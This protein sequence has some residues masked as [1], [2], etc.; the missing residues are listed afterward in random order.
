MIDGLQ[1]LVGVGP[2]HLWKA[3]NREPRGSDE[4][5]ELLFALQK[6]RGEQ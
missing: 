5:G 6:F 2:L 4:D 1:S 3:A